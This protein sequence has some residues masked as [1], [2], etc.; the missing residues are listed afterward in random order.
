VPSALNAAHTASTHMRQIPALIRLLDL[1]VVSCRC[2]GE[3][4]A[5][6]A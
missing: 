2:R 3:Q 5:L 6:P 4:R 1:I